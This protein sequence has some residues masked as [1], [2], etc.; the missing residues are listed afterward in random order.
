MAS[1]STNDK[2]LEQELKE[3]KEN[4]PEHLQDNSL[5]LYFRCKV[6][7]RNLLMSKCDPVDRAKIE[8]ELERIGRLRS[9]FPNNNSENK[10]LI[11]NLSNSQREW[12]ECAKARCHEERIKLGIAGS[13]E[14]RERHAC[15][16]ETIENRPPPVTSSQNDIGYGFRAS[17]ITL[18]RTGTN[19]SYGDYRIKSHAVN[20]ILIKKDNNPL[21]QRC[22]DNAI[23]YFHFPANH[24]LWVEVCCA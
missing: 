8:W 15:S 17:E 21:R 11:Q 13:S 1:Q 4:T 24:M 10:L 14:S 2:I 3:L 23:R 22:E 20:D 12:R 9:E 7:H 19:F 18:K 5:I 16:L 6:S